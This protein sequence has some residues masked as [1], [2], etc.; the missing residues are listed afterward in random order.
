MQNTQAY[1]RYS[2]IEDTDITIGR[3]LVETFYVR[4]NDTKMIPNPFD[5]LV[6]STKAI[7]KTDLKIAYLE[8]RSS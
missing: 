5:G 3:Q 1:V 4:S 6:I 2:G 7:A 8:T